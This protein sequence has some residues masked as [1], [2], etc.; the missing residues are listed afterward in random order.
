MRN[1]GSGVGGRKC[2]TAAHVCAAFKLIRNLALYFFVC[3]TDLFG[4][5]GAGVKH[6][7]EAFRNDYRF[8]VWTRDHWWWR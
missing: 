2:G 7:Y 6:G 5:I 1:R 3:V 8:R 4:A